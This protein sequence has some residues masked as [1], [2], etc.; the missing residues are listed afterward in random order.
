MIWY[1]SHSVL[2]RLE[3]PF[4]LSTGL[5]E[6]YELSQTFRLEIFPKIVNGLKAWS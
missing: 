6:T 4:W 2:V 1:S 5:S 3:L